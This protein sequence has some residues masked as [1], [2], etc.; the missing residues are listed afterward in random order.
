VF[1]LEARVVKKS[2]RLL[3]ADPVFAFDLQSYTTSDKKRRQLSE[4]YGDS[5]VS[6]VHYGGYLLVV[7]AFQTKD[8]GAKTAISASISAAYGDAKGK[9]SLTKELSSRSISVQ[10]EYKQGRAGGRQVV[11]DGDLRGY[12]TG[13]SE[14]A[15][16][17]DGETAV[18][19]GTIAYRKAFPEPFK[20]TKPPTPK[21]KAVK[22][23][24]S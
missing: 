11:L 10:K 18:Y 12:L 1:V 5:L 19:F 23:P 4:R 21:V 16:T 9:G 24:R 8:E 20:K 13:V 6:E 7:Y 14:W 15:A 22:R 3:T 17:V 2:E